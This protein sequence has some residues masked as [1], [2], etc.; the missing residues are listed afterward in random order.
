MPKQPAHSTRSGIVWD[1]CRIESIARFAGGEFDGV[2]QNR[3]TLRVEWYVVASIVLEIL[4]TIF[5]IWRRSI[6]DT[7][8]AN[9][10]RT[11]SRIG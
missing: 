4:L 8:L 2:L 6:R 3:R 7:I 11:V 10:L 5:Q 1:P 9:G